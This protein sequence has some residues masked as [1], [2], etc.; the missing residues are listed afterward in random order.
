MFNNKLFAI[1]I[2][3]LIPI[4]SVQNSFSTSFN[5]KTSGEK[6]FEVNYKVSQPQVLFLSN[7]P[8]EDIRGSVNS[9]SISGLITFD[10]ANIENA[11]GIITIEVKGMETGIQK[12]NGHLYSKNWL[13]GETYPNITFNLIQLSGVKIASSDPAKG[14]ATANA[15]ASGT[16]S[17]HGKLKTINV[18]VNIT[19]IKESEETK[20]RASGD[21]LSV[22]GKFDVAL[23][24]FDITGAQGLIG[25]KVGEVINIDLSLFFSSK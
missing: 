6:K 9:E 25:S 17:I 13:D 18:D 7:A 16:I 4:F 22:S 3:L 10:P 15:I 12:R 21:F 8:L 19:Y 5:L 1:I 2:A 14:R 23:K 11:K 20:K 24:D